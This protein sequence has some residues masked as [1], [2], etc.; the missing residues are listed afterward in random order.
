VFSSGQGV[1]IG[2]ADNPSPLPARFAAF[3][4]HRAASPA[5]G[6]GG[7]PVFASPSPS[8]VGPLAGRLGVRQ[9][10]VRRMPGALHAAAA[11][12]FGFLVVAVLRGP[13]AGAG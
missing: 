6:V 3:G 11:C 2:D 13:Q 4:I 7:S 12:P 1:K 10:M 5:D 9:A 8:P